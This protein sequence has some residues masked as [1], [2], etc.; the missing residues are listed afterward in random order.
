MFETSLRIDNLGAG[1]SFIHRSHPAVK[2]IITFVLIG[3]NS[4]AENILYSF[5][6]TMICLVLMLLAR[7]TFK[8]IAKAYAFIL[9]MI[10]GLLILYGILLGLTLDLV[11]NVVINLSS[12]GMP[13]IFL[14][15]TSPILKTLYG[16]EFLLTPLKYLKVPVNAIVLISTIALNFIPIVI[17]EMQRILNSMA[18]RGRD[19]RFAKFFDK[20]KIF[21]TALI[22]LLIS[23]LKSTETLASA[24]AASNYDAWNPRTNILSTKWKF[25]DTLFLITVL[26]CFYGIYI[27][28]K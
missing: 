14:I 1:N 26:S 10:I 15:Y 28:I 18:V 8:Q 27:L 6:L 16:I 4:F 13:V 7:V 20:I 22:P 23:T 3:I 17:S 12:V 25:T 21:M 11:L 5:I 9:F 19:I 24:I 2:V